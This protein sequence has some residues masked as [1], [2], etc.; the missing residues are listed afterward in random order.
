MPA[1][2]VTQAADLVSGYSA[3][4]QASL[5]AVL[6]RLTACVNAIEADVTVL[7]VAARLARHRD[8]LYAA[9]DALGGWIT[10]FLATSPPAAAI[11]AARARITGLIWPWSHTGPF[12]D[13]CCGKRRSDLGDFETIE[14]IHTCRPGGVD[15][16]ARLFDDYYLHTRAARAIRSRLAYLTGRLREET[17]RLAGEGVFPVRV[18]TLD[19][20]PARELRVLVED[21]VFRAVAAV[22]C[23]DRDAEA[24]RFVRNRLQDNLN[25]RMAYL[26]IDP[27]RFARSPARPSRPFHLIYATGLFDYLSAEQ[28]AALIGDC[29]SLL[30]PGGR[31]IASSF[32]VGLPANERALLAW[33]L[34]WQ[35]QGRTEAD[36][37]RIF[38][39]N[40]F[41]ADGLRFAHD[42]VAPNLFVEAVAAG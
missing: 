26:R 18:L 31:F 27:L 34:A 35:L 40:P 16:R 39:Q 36:Y 21:P 1:T 22:T 13:R 7:S 12:F 8:T 37:R 20:G 2:G 19:C 23:L 25:G 10:G 28:A 30:A 3:E 29:H 6:A 32:S 33:L 38:D 5:D 41:P 14:L 11:E 17:E 15:F 9:M 24:L 4:A 42:P